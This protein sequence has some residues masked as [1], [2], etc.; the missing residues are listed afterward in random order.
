MLQIHWQTT[1][2]NGDVW[3]QRNQL[4]TKL[5]S[6]VKDGEVGDNLRKPSNNTTK[7]VLRGSPEGKMKRKDEE[8]RRRGKMKRKDEEER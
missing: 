8:E 5:R 2:R 3:Q 7:Q 1:I 4:P 6:G